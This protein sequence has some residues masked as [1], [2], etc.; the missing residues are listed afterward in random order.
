[1][2]L[3]YL[4]CKKTER[5]PRRA[6]GL[7]L[8]AGCSGHGGGAA[9]TT[10]TDVVDRGRLDV[11][12]MGF[13]HGRVACRPQRRSPLGYFVLPKYTIT[14]SLFYGMATAQLSRTG[15]TPPGWLRNWKQRDN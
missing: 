6:R 5:A 4:M 7:L 13:W 12:P 10:E 15:L 1:M 2:S 8:L 9:L 3:P 14:P 11:K